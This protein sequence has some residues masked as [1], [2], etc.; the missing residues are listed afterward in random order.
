ML[1]KFGLELSYHDMHGNLHL[2]QLFLALQYHTGTL[3]RDSA[4]YCFHDKRYPKPLNEGDMIEALIPSCKFNV[5]YPGTFAQ[6]NE[7]GEALIATGLYADALDVLR[8]RLSVQ[9]TCFGKSP[10]L[11]AKA[12]ITATTYKY[13][14]THFLMGDY[15]GAQSVLLQ[16]LKSHHTYEALAGR[17]IALLMSIEFKLGNISRATVYF[18]A[19]HDVYNFVL[20][21]HHPIIGLHAN[22]LS[23]HYRAQGL[24]SQTK[25]MTLLSYESSKR[26]LGETHIA[27]AL[28]GYKLG[29]IMIEEKRFHEASELLHGVIFILDEAT[30]RGI[31]VQRDL[32]YALHSLAEALVQ[33]DELDYGV[34]CAMRAMDIYGTIFKKVVPPRVVSCL[35]LLSDLFIKQRKFQAAVDGLNQIW[36]VVKYRPYDYPSVG[37]VLRNVCCNIFYTL[38]LSLPSQTMALLQTVAKE[39][40]PQIGR[41]QFDQAYNIVVNAVWLGKGQE[42]FEALVAS[43]QQHESAGGFSRTSWPRELRLL[44]PLFCCC[45]GLC[46]CVISLV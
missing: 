5:V 3:F 35:L 37:D 32:A 11:K 45:C 12:I 46:A 27:T 1:Q 19:A 20:G 13:A 42:Y 44:I 15:E 43:V 21:P 2:P 38:S 6:S 9:G 26:V 17:M 34:D 10:S 16:H 22:L 4:D 28:S 23:D 31:N 29:V 33:R 40:S 25:V 14:L 7:V 18:D 41:T 39:V 24:T 8:L 36:G 30:D